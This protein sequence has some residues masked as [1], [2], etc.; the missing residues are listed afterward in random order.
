MTKKKAGQQFDVAVIGGGMVGAATAIGLASAGIK[1]VMFEHQAPQAFDPDQ[2][3]DLRV[4]AINL[5]S[6][7]LLSSL[8]VWDTLE[9][10]RVHPYE[11]MRVWERSGSCEFSAD[12]CG[13]D[14]LGYFVE[15]RLLQLALHQRAERLDKVDIVYGTHIDQ[16]QW[17]GPCKLVTADEKEYHC[18]WVIAADGVNSRTRT[19][20]GISTQGWQYSQQ[21]LAVLVKLRG[22]PTDV[23]WQQFSPHGPMALL[24]L[25]DHHAAL[26]WYHDKTRIAELKALSHADLKP[27]IVAAFPDALEDF[28]ILQTGSFPIRRLHANSYHR[29]NLLLIGDAAHS[30][31]PMAGQGVNLGFKDLNAL[32][33][34]LDKHGL[35]EDD[36]TLRELF[37]QYELRRRYD[38][39]LMMS[40]MDVL[41]ATFSND[42]LPV[43]LLRNAGLDIA[44]KL[45]PLKNQVLR[46]ATGM[47]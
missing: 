45:T 21:V 34:L 19:S 30:I 27:E 22:G 8:G 1:V 32:L 43:R 6:Q 47:D 11:R 44:G 12:E 26:I 33:Q 24:P 46:Y 17:R 18:R 28:E 10:M 3:P 35:P 7:R 4:S 13:Q 23:T 20:A 31:N 36:A 9:A 2:P 38:N 25:F 15:N 37:R 5:G 16:L 29:G 39:L 42:I 41:Y 40:V 14:H